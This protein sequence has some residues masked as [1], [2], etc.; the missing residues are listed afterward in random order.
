MQ[1]SSHKGSGVG[2]EVPYSGAG[3]TSPNYP[4]VQ[5]DP[6]I[7]SRLYCRLS[8]SRSVSIVLVKFRSWFVQLV[9]W[10]LSNNEVNVE[11]HL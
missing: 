6:T 4:T 10:V 11:Q 5:P 7:I 3:G 1:G 2:C 8:H 9:F